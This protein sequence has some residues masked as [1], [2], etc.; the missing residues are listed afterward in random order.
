[1]AGLSKS[2]KCASKN[3]TYNKHVHCIYYLLPLFIK[4]ENKNKNMLK[5]SLYIESKIVH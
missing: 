2:A 1:M 5:H 4:R 3:T